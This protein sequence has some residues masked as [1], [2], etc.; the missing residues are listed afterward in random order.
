MNAWVNNTVV[1][2]ITR[3]AADVNHSG[4]LDPSDATS[5]M[6]AWVNATGFSW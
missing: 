6:N 1:D 4:A 3:I 5:I 2:D